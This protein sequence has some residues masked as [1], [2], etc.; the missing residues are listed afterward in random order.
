[1]IGHNKLGEALLRLFFWSCGGRDSGSSFLVLLGVDSEESSLL[2]FPVS[3]ISGRRPWVFISVNC[4][5]LWAVVSGFIFYV[6]CITAACP[7]IATVGTLRGGVG[8][9]GRGEF[10]LRLFIFLSL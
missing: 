1:M 4:G 8:A 7:A 5:F 2:F 10:L 9:G 3:G 6:L